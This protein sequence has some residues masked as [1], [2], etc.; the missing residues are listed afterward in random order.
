MVDSKTGQI[1][2]VLNAVD[3]TD[4]AIAFAVPVRVLE[5]FVTRV[6]PYLA[7]SIFR[8]IK[9]IAPVSAD[10][11]PKFVPVHANLLQHRTRENMEV[12]S[13]RTKAQS[14]SE[15]MRDFIAV[16]S[17][18]WGS[19]NNAPAAE[20]RYEIQVLQGAPRF[21]EFP[22][23]K[24]ELKEMSYPPLSRAVVPGSEWSELPLKVGTD[25]DL[26]ISQAPDA[27]V[28]GRSIKIFRYW[29]SVEDGACTVRT[30]DFGLFT[31]RKTFVT[32][33]YGEVWADQNGDI[34]RISE[35]FEFADKQMNLQAVVTYG[36]L[37]RTDEEP[38]IV[39]LTLA[40]QT[41]HKNKVHWCR[42]Q[43]TDYRVFTSRVRIVES[44]PGASGML[45]Q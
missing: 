6:Q 14:L 22:D 18:A 25:L 16:Q 39:P 30:I 2:G 45:S 5:E 33:C 23:G 38:R 3:E 24:K 28:N 43:F 8:S 4:K 12:R 21:R 20:S 42:S 19:Q 11:Y 15:G 17:L 29:A 1:V 9:Q 36:W 34:L 32:A 13:L 31:V 27:V 26:K 10:I 37:K 7:H 35:H 40:M 41:E 44:T